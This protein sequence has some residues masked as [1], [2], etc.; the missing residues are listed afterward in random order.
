MLLFGAARTRGLVL[1]GLLVIALGALFAGS[2]VGTD[3]QPAPASAQTTEPVVAM[4]AGDIACGADSFFEKCL[5]R[6]TSDLLVGESPDV[7]LPLGDLQYECGEAS[8]FTTYYDPTWGRVKSRTRPVIGNH[9]YHTSTDPA[10]P[11]YGNPP[12]GKAYFDYFGA[13]AG[14]EGK[15]YYS[16]DIRGV[17]FIALNSMCDKVGGCGAGSPQ[18]QWLRADLAANSSTCTVAYWHHP[19][20]TSSIKKE[21][22]LRF[23][24]FWQVLYDAGADIVLNAHAHNYERFAPQNP[25]GGADANYGLRQWTV[26][27]GGKNYTG[28]DAT[29][30]P[31]SEAVNSGTFGVLRLA[32]HSDRYEWKFVP[33]AGSTTGFADSGSTPCHGAP[34]SG[35]T[36]PPV[37][38]A[39]RH[40]LAQARLGSST[41]PVR[42]A[43]SATDDS[44]SVA[45]YEVQRS[46]DG[47]A[48]AGVSLASA[49]TTTI[50]QQLAPSH[51]YQYRVRAKDPAGNTSAWATGTSFYLRARQEDS[52][53]IAYGGTW[54]RSSLS[55]A[56]GGYVNHRSASGGK[57]TFGFTGT[58]VS[59]VSTRGANRGKAEVWLDGALI[60]TVDLYKSSTSTR[61]TVFTRGGLSPSTTHTLEIRVTGTRNASSTG[62]RVDLDALAVLR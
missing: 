36:T 1:A 39:P 29:L 46:V 60:T 4:A 3:E 21:N 8:D 11:C 32:I 51:T 57:A 22:D 14:A 31:N 18:E 35:D 19:M 53:T 38:T 41:I 15:G 50:T 33:A 9:E 17:H 6:E 44:G 24:P 49:T 13:A 52:S 20:F 2:M 28:L 54:T 43:W 16:Y 7:V 61:E 23:Q 5:Q 56:F 55:G 25:T 42:V 58:N 30:Q 27:T 34:S 26:G 40:S 10:H 47:G 48:F 62:T 37:V 59:W 12:G 45:G